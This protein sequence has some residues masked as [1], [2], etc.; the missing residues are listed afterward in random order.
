MDSTVIMNHV[1][2]LNA[3]CP[4]YTMYPLEF[5]LRVLQRNGK[6]GDHVL[7]PFCGRGTTNFAARMLKMPSCGIDSSRIAV[8]LAQA[9]LL[10]VTAGQVISSARRIL[11]G[12]RRPQDVPNSRFWR[13]AY[14]SR[15]LH[16]LCCL[17]QALLDHC[18][19][20]TRI[21]LRAIILGALHGPMTKKVPSYFSNQSPRTFAPKP[22]YAVKFWCERG[23]RA[24]EVDVL[25]VIARRAD[26]Y[27]KSQP[28][29]G[30]GLIIHG[31]SRDPTTLGEDRRFSW[32]VTSPPYYGMR[33]YI[34]DQWLRNWFLGGPS[35]VEYG[36]P[37]EEMG[38]SS[39]EAY[40]E[41]LRS[42]W[43]NAARVCRPGA[44][45]V[46]RFGGIN[47]RKQEP[48][49]LLKNS[50]HDSGWRIQ[51]IKAAGTA[52]DGKRQARQFGRVTKPRVEYDLY[53][54][55]A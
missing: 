50:I 38:H 8:A 27:L 49:D 54:V 48:L 15:T 21:V 12:T 22:R 35:E 4:Y 1:T 16:D 46:S 33:T 37:L 55:K 45:L 13:R 39:P 6:P 44:R 25:R 36:P 19:S 34:P 29:R 11:Q 5:P 51:T 23:L 53:A 26:W 24:P 43:R 14:H 9:K 41:Q 32:V 47:D 28:G 3:V 17:R 42:V 30:S 10:R 18:D 2:A 52:N 7:D 20:E 40:A 31:D